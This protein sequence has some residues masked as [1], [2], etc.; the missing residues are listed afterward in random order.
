MKP[1]RVTKI[2]N[3]IFLFDNRAEYLAGFEIIITIV[4]TRLT[5]LD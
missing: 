2:M 3:V 5:V 1:D 4:M